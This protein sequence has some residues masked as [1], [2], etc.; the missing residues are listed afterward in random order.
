MF[1]RVIW[2]WPSN[3]NTSRKEQG[4]STGL[5]YTDRDIVWELTL[6]KRKSKIRKKKT[7]DIGNW[8]K[9]KRGKGISQMIWKGD[10]GVAAG[11]W[12]GAASPQLE[13]AMRKWNWENAWLGLNLSNWGRIGEWT[14]DKWTHNNRGEVLSPGKLKL[15]KRCKVILVSSW[16]LGSGG[17]AQ[18]VCPGMGVAGWVVVV[19]GMCELQLNTPLV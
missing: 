12:L 2:Q 1:S 13:Q 19:V 18:G 10:P 3:S 16:L 4:E 14:R 17:G 9:F 15:C 8:I 6:P 11:S 5:S 7:P